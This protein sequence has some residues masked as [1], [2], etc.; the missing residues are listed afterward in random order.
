MCD[1]PRQADYPR[2][3]V[4]HSYSHLATN[5]RNLQVRLKHQL[6]PAKTIT[7]LADCS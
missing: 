7:E 4:L 6:E 2:I 5:F 1:P 3:A